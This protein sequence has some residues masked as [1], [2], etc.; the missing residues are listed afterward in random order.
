[1]G[2]A[3]G[4]EIFEKI[5]KA[6]METIPDESQRKKFYTPVLDAFWN[7]DWDCTDECC[8]VDPV[9]DAKVDEIII[10]D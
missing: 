1:M 10:N 7:A 4:T 5:I 9:F 2:W 8:G 3:S 6:A